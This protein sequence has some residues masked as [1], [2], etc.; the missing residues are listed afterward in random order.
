MSDIGLLLLIIFVV[1]ILF[2]GQKSLPALGAALGRGVKEA[3]QSFERG[4]AHP[5]DDDRPTSS[6]E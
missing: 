2:R 6:S 4:S 5:P 3:R 1:V